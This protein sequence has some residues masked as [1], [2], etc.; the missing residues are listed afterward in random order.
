MD[1][2]NLDLKREIILNHYEN[3]KY[4]IEGNEKFV[5]KYHIANKDS[6]SCIDNITIY[7]NVVNKKIVDLRFSGIGCAVATSSTDI[8]CGLLIKKNLVDARKIINNYYNLVANKKY[9]QKLI[10][11]LYVFDNIYKQLNRIKCATVGIEAIA[12]AIEK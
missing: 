11:D 3:P 9:E 5:K 6:P 10:G 1:S 2:K 12:K 8:M 4:K 7:A